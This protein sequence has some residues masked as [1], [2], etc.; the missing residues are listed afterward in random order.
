MKSPELVNSDVSTYLSAN[1]KAAGTGQ[2]M[3]RA[4]IITGMLAGLTLLLGDMIGFFAFI[5]PVGLLLLMPSLFLY[6]LAVWGVSAIL[7][8]RRVWLARG[9]ALVIVLGLASLAMLALR[10]GAIAD[11]ERRAGVPDVIPPARIALAGDVRIEEG[12][13]ATSRVCDDLC[14]AV[15]DMDGVTSVTVADPQGATTF[16]LVAREDADPAAVAQPRNPGGF[17]AWAKSE[18]R[19]GEDS[20]QVEALWQARLAGP[21]RLVRSAP[22]TRADYTL[23]PSADEILR[24]RAVIARRTTAVVRVPII[25]PFL[26]PSHLASDA[27][28]G[29]GPLT[30]ATSLRRAGPSPDGE[31][32]YALFGRWLALKTY[33]PP[34]DQSAASSP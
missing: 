28:Y 20:G 33:D 2:A 8:I 7:P 17:V 26:F 5:P 9:A 30:L 16:R 15:L 29:N 34:R 18:G 21:E 23:R 19:S 1:G 6:L 31:H 22:V 10:L 25:P 12:Y 14:L 27:A 32:P 24:R 4:V 11:F 3:K 13:A